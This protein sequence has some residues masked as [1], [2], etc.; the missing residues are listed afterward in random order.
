MS[1]SL[2]TYISLC[3]SVTNLSFF[4]A[5]TSSCFYTLILKEIMVKKGTHYYGHMDIAAVWVLLKEELQHCQRNAQYLI[6]L[7]VLTL[8]CFDPISLI[9]LVPCILAEWRNQA[10]KKSMHQVIR[11]RSCFQAMAAGTILTSD[12]WHHECLWMAFLP[13]YMQFLFLEEVMISCLMGYP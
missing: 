8:W 6:T 13:Q 7:N 9:L 11:Q 3:L 4:L 10:N 2:P 1:V 5:L 12:L